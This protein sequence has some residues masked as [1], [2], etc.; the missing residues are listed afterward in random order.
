MYVEIHAKKILRNCQL[1]I[2]MTVPAPTPFQPA[3]YSTR[4]AGTF[5]GKPLIVSV[6]IHFLSN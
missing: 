4:S 3:E 5:A 2:A 1:S 6:F